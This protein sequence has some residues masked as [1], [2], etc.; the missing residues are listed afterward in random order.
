MADPENPFG[1]GGGSPILCDRKIR[2]LGRFVIYI[3]IFFGGPVDCPHLDPPLKH[4]L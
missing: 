4:S 3:A 2:N 1:G